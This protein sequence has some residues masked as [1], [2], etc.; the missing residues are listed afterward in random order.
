MRK[1][2]MERWE[3]VAG[4]LVAAAVLPAVASEGGRGDLPS[5][6]EPVVGHGV[7][8]WHQLTGWFHLGPFPR[9]ALDDEGRPRTDLGTFA[10]DDA[11]VGMSGGVV[12]WK[13]VEARGS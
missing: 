6:A 9:A 1:C 12:R 7:G 8:G 2:P 11:A 5:F 4:W 3:V 10:L 13:W